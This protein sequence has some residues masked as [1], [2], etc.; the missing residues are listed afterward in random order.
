M[1]VAKKNMQKL[2][3]SG[4]TFYLDDFGVG[5]SNFNCVLELPLRTIKLDMS[6]TSSSKEDNSYGL[7]GILTDLF[8]NMGLKVV[9]EGAETDDQVEML[10]EYGVDGIQGYYFARPMPIHRLR[11]FLK[12]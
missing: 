3:E 11:E 12:K 8:H 7:V 5:Y 4:Y 2:S 6:L 9:A 1:D 10:K